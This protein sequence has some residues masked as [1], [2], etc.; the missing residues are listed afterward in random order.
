MPLETEFYFQFGIPFGKFGTTGANDKGTNKITRVG[1]GK[2]NKSV[3]MDYST[4]TVNERLW[5]SGNME[6]FDAAVKDKNK[7]EVIKILKEVQL[8]DRNIL[9]ILLHFGLR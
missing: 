7:D 1:V 4:M 2:R 3:F 5:T 6:K 8:D 9:P